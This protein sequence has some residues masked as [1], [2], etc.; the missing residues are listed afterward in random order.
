MDPASYSIVLDGIQLEAHSLTTS[1]LGPASC[2]HLLKDQQSRDL[3]YHPNDIGSC[4]LSVLTTLHIKASKLT[5]S[6][7]HDV[8]QSPVLASIR[9]GHPQ[10]QTT[11]FRTSQ[12]LNCAWGPTVQGPIRQ[13]ISCPAHVLTIVLISYQKLIYSQKRSWTHKSAYSQTPMFQIDM[14]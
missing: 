4:H 2:S 9:L 12:P 10:F 6:F 5:Q 3:H 7:Q 1:L 14:N 8:S 11:D 13:S